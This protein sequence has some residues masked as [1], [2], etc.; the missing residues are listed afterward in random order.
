MSWPSWLLPLMVAG[1]I[2]WAFGAY[3]RL[4]RERGR[5]IA[6]FSVLARDIEDRSTVLLRMAHAQLV[7]LADA[8]QESLWHRLEACVQQS[9]N[10]V[11]HAAVRPLDGDRVATLAAAQS[12]LSAALNDVRHDT[13]DLAGAPWPSEVQVE[14]SRTEARVMT[15]GEN[16]NAL[17]VAHNESLAQFPTSALAWVFGLKP[18]R[19][20]VPGD[21]KSGANLR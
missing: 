10:A 4:M 1:L 13:H 3:N 15:Q 18:A 11:A 16:F 2:F 12:A 19:T 7:H 17:V 8:Q 14:L 21:S 6:A 5:A 20:L 9:A